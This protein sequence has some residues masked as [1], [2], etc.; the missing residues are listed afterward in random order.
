M[1]FFE[2]A[3]EIVVVAEI[4]HGGD[5]ADPQMTAGQQ[6]RGTLHFLFHDILR[7]R[8]GKNFR[9]RFRQMKFPR[10]WTSPFHGQAMPVSCGS[11]RIPRFADLTDG[12]DN[13]AKTEGMSRQNG[14]CFRISPQPDLPVAGCK[15]I[16][17][18]FL[19]RRLDF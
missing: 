5:L 9:G 4:E 12:T 2:G 8:E 18:F 11:D 13:G 16:Q 1:V 17:L 19:F 3:G 7:R 14:L 6:P 10:R 15:H